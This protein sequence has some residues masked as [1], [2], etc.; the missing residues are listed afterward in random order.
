MVKKSTYDLIIVGGGPSGIWA[1]YYAAHRGLSVALIEINKFLGGLPFYIYPTKPIYDVPGITNI[2]GM[3]FT[4]LMIKQMNTKINQIKIY[5]DVVISSI[6][7]DELFHVFLKDGT[8]ITAKCL[9]FSQGNGVAIPKTLVDIPVINAPI[10]YAIR[11]LVEL[12]NKDV[13][14]SGGGDSAL[15]YTL[16]LSTLN[17]KNKIYL[18]HRRNEFR[19]DKEKVNKILARKNTIIFTSCKLMKINQNPNDR[20]KVFI[21]IPK[22]DK[23]IECD[24]VLIQHGFQFKANDLELAGLKLDKLSKIKKY[25]TTTNYESSINKCYITGPL[26]H[27]YSINLILTS[28][29]EVTVAICHMIDNY[30]ERRSKL[31]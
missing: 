19:G 29:Y 11:N 22:G 21:N 8:E 7:N 12:E 10:K 17:V 13:L 6:T 1:A 4:D 25:W 14:I 30:F 15:D 18:I 23:V 5:I 27:K 3:S 9:L 31:Y 28:I 16:A 26:K 24:E 2:N 20:I